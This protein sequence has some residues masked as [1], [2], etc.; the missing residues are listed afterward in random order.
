MIRGFP[1][2]ALELMS[3]SEDIIGT[4]STGVKEAV[5]M[6][7]KMTNIPNKSYRILD[8]LYE[9]KC[10]RKKFSIYRKFK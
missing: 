5:M 2:T 6:N 9:E 3:V 7:R 8:E 10:P 4:D 1:P